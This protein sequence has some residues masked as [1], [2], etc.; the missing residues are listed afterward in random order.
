[1]ISTRSLHKSMAA[2]QIFGC[3]LWQHDSVCCW[4]HLRKFHILSLQCRSCRLFCL[5]CGS[6][7]FHTMILSAV[8]CGC[9][10]SSVF[11]TASQ[12]QTDKH[13]PL[14]HASSTSLKTVK[15]S[16]MAIHQ[17]SEAPCLTMG[18][19]DRLHRIDR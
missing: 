12:N 9:S 5:C 18:I 3:S 6:S 17:S 13:T 19:S 2:R 4:C 11:G 15:P 14:R 1:M 8:P 10:Y 7:L 16:P